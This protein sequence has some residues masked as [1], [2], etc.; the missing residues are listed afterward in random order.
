M[1]NI[2]KVA[3]ID[4]MSDYFRHSTANAEKRIAH[5]LSVL[6]F[7]ERIL[8]GEGVDSSFVTI[9]A[10]LAALFH[11]IGIPEAERKHGSTE[12]QYQHVEGPPITRGILSQLNL[13]PDVVERVCF[14]VGN[15]HSKALIDAIDFQVVY[16][17]DYIVNTTEE[18]KSGTGSPDAAALRRRH[19]EH[20]HTKTA[21]AIM[22]EIS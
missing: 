17:A 12:P 1:E 20:L 19:G 4:A 2:T 9:V 21:V 14:I 15:H 7:A 8:T 3:A 6:S 10:V 11:D 18:A 13:R 5:T 16:E 22:G